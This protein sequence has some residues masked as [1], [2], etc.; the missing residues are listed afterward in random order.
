[1]KS[2]IYEEILSVLTPMEKDISWLRFAVYTD[3]KYR[4]LDGKNEQYQILRQ[5]LKQLLEKYPE[6]SEGKLAHLLSEMVNT[7]S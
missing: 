2:I 5:I 1:M 7:N 4:I 3:G 6:Q